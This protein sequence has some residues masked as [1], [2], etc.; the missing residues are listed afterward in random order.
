M[1]KVVAFVLAGGKG[2]RLRPFTYVLPKPLLPVG[3]RP[4]LELIIERLGFYGVKD[5]IIATGYKS[6]YIKTFFADGRKFDVNISYVEE[7]VALGTCGPLSLAKDILSQDDLIVLMNGDIYTELDF[8]ALISK[9]RSSD[10]QLMVCYR[11]FQETSRF[12]ELGV[13]G[14]RIISVI[15]KPERSSLINAG[16]YVLRGELIKSIPEGAF[17]TV[18]DLITSLLGKGVPVGAYKIEEFWKGIEYQQDLEEVVQRVS[19]FE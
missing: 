14:D 17:F 11:V 6:S 9:F 13:S 16:I 2:T 12:G 5:I 19:D 8:S 18:P 1:S 4:I 10:Y 3:R 7:S 15:E